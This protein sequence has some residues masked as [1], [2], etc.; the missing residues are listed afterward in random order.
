MIQENNKNMQGL[1]EYCRCV[2]FARL[3]RINHFQGVL[4]QKS[5]RGKETS[6]QGLY[7]GRNT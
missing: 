7:A 2:I 3:K 6:M 4:Y 5:L 1:A